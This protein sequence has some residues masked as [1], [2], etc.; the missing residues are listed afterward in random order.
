[1]VVADAALIAHH[2]VLYG[3]VRHAFLLHGEYVQ[4]VAVLADLSHPG[5]DRAVKYHIAKRGPGKLD[6]PALGYCNGGPGRKHHQ[7]RGKYQKSYF[8]DLPS[9]P[10]ENTVCLPLLYHAAFSQ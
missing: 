10:V 7:G 3:Y 4:V 2:H 1:A 8:N 6:L 5:V 9:F